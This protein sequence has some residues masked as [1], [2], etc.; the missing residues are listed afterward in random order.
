MSHVPVLLNAVFRSVEKGLTLSSFDALCDFFKENGVEIIE[1]DFTSSIS[2]SSIK[3]PDNNL[4]IFI[5]RS[6]NED[7]KMLVVL[8][9]FLE[10]HIE[11]PANMIGIR[12]IL[13]IPLYE[14]VVKTGDSTL[15][16][17]RPVDI[18]RI[19]FAV[20]YDYSSR[21]ISIWGVC[22]DVVDKVKLTPKREKKL[23]KLFNKKLSNAYRFHEIIDLYY[24]PVLRL[25]LKSSWIPPEIERDLAIRLI[26]E[27]AHLVTECVEAN[28]TE[29]KNNFNN[30]KQRFEEMLGACEKL[31]KLLTENP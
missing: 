4:V 29:Y 7:E 2:G 14:G 12:E 28:R 20:L 19:F 5:N 26:N 16:Q 10:S 13:D 9:E 25:F 31:K 22:S 21:E 8:H 24:V 17:G 30:S 23:N 15:G 11:Y 27:V 18:A 1:T 6:L 3:A